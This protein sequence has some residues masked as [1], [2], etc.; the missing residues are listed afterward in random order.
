MERRKFIKDVALTA[1]ISNILP[2][3]SISWSHNNNMSNSD[4]HEFSIGD[5][6]CSIFKDLM[7][8]YEAKDYFINAPQEELQEVLTSRKIDPSNI[9]SPFIALLLKKDNRNILVD[10]G[11]GYA[12][13]PII[14]RGNEFRFKGQLTQLLNNSNTHCDQITDVIITH[15]HPD[16]IGGIFSEQGVVNYPNATFHFHEE[17]WNFWNSSKSDGQPPLFKFFIENNISKIPEH[18]LNLIK[19]DY[20]EILPGITTIQAFGHTPGQMAIIIKDKT[21]Q[22][23][24]TSDAFL[25]P[26]H[27]ENL[28]WRTNYDFDHQQSRKTRLKLL[29]LAFEDNMLMNV[30]HFDFPGIGTVKKNKNNWKWEYQPY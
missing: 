8:K 6:K 19:G 1:G 4:S 23:F 17:E 29:D 30:F 21:D 22:L 9:P 27:I 15:F 14:F 7:F 20:H 28:D 5:F 26:L 13:D 16:H 3:N 18:Q 12:E 10:T 11:I 25:H 2:Y 24:Y